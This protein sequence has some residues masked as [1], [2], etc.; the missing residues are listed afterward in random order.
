MSA[1]LPLGPLDPAAQNNRINAGRNM[2]PVVWSLCFI[3]A[4]RATSITATAALV[5]VIK[6]Q[7]I[8]L[9]DGVR[10][11]GVGG[12]CSC[13]RCWWLVFV[14][15]MFIA[16]VRTGGVRGWLSCW[17]RSWV[18]FVLAGICTGGVRG[19]LSHWRR[20]LLAFVLAVFVT[21][22]RTGGV[23]DW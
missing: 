1:V 7:G 6:G 3:N 23:R 16:G 12:W 18:A 2:H 14:L 8:A 5:A 13:W 22:V 15:A 9:V 11:G 4:A 19:W 17:Q 10:T 20:S 21:G